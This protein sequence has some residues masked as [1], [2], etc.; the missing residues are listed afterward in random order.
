MEKN[1]QEFSMQDA[2][3]AAQSEAGQ[4]LLALLQRTD[5][6]ML[7]KAMQQAA[8]GNLTEAKQALETLMASPEAKK[9]VDQLGG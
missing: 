3:R 8:A 2:V 9:L 6:Q 4:Q 1:S 7:Q 5:P